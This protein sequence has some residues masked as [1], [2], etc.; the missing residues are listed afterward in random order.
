MTTVWATGIE[1]IAFKSPRPR[2]FPLDGAQPDFLLD[3]DAAINVAD[4]HA[5]PGIRPVPI[6]GDQAEI[7]VVP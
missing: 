3:R 6:D 7:V 1:E 2:A 4:L 5:D